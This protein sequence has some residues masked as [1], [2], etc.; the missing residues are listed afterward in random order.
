LLVQPLHYRK[1]EL[2]ELEGTDVRDV[3]ALFTLCLCA[4]QAHAIPVTTPVDLPQDAVALGSF[5]SNASSD[6]SLKFDATTRRM[7]Y[8]VHMADI[9]PPGDHSAF[10]FGGTSFGLYTWTIGV[11]EQGKLIG[12]SGMSFA[13][14]VGNGLELLA[15]GKAIDFGFEYTCW[16]APPEA[17]L[18]CVMGMPKV[19]FETT[20][21]DA[22]IAQYMGNY[23]EYTGYVH[24]ISND[25]GT[26]LTRDFDCTY[27]SVNCG[28]FSGDVTFGYVVP[29]P[30]SMVLVGLALLGLGW[31]V[32]NRK[33][34]GASRLST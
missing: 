8:S 16:D 28:R 18:P 12:D 33:R 22:R 25:W 24:L 19:L 17:G 32:V 26:L 9:H 3:L 34:Y 14:D 1:Q 23:W 2:S 10:P 11:D 20:Y 7:N 31:T 6:W 29:E 15:T 30:S 5:Y 27:P 13:M 21:L 4:A